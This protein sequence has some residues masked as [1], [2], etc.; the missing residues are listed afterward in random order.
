MSKLLQARKRLQTWR[1]LVPPRSAQE[2]IRFELARTSYALGDTTLLTLLE[3]QR[4]ALQAR[5]TR[6]EA[7]L[8]AARTRVEV[9]RAAGAS[10]ELLAE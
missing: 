7:L 6:I 5:S 8:E 9:E 10:L 4:A 1:A 3:S 2:R